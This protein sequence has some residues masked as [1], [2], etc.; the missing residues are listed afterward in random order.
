[1]DRPYDSIPRQGRHE[2]GDL[3]EEPTTS[4]RAQPAPHPPARE[5]EPPA[6]SFGLYYNE[7]D[8]IYRIRSWHSEAPGEAETGYT[9]VGTYDRVDAVVE[10]LPEYARF[11]VFEN[12]E[13]GEVYYDREGNI[14][15][16]LAGGQYARISIFEDETA[17]A[18]YA[19]A[20]Q[21]R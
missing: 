16:G 12:P 1:M 20:L 14:T 7:R 9:T 19:D 4:V 6:P 2:G 11:I 13:T 5:P 8:G 18:A 21:N 3:E 17:A 15:G 10:H